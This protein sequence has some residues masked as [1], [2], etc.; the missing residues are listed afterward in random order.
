MRRGDQCSE[1]PLLRRR[2]IGPRAGVRIARRQQVHVRVHLAAVAQR[3]RAE[4]AEPNGHPAEEERDEPAEERGRP[5]ARRTGRARSGAPGS[6]ARSGR[7]MTRRFCCSGAGSSRSTGY[8]PGLPT[9]PGNGL[10]TMDRNAVRC[11]AYRMYRERNRWNGDGT[12]PITSA[13][14]QARIIVEPR[15]DRP[16]QQP[17]DVGD[18][19]RQPEER[20]DP[21]AAELVRDR[22]R[23]RVRLG[24]RERLGG[25]GRLQARGRRAPRP[26]RAGRPSG[27]R[28]RLRRPEPRGAR[29]A[30]P[31]RR[32]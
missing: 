10:P 15:D 1:R 12:R 30:R 20:E 9:N 22:H 4:A 26:G 27:R 19:D 24:L 5:R 17:D 13:H 31:R 18:R 8:V 25:D 23:D 21:G 6:R 29:R 11:V 2:R 32:R 16:E 3:V 28:P 7:T 14:S